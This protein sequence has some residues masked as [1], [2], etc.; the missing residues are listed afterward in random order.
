MSEL[1]GPPDLQRL[2]DLPGVTE[3]L[4]PPGV[5]LPPS[6]PQAPW[7]TRV[8]ATVWWHRAVRGAAGVLPEVLDGPP[9]LP[10]TVAALVRYLDS[11]VGAY[12]EV[13]ASPVLLLSRLPRL[14][15]PFIAVDSLASVRGGRERWGLPKGLAVFDEGTASGAGWQVRARAVLRGPELPVYLPLPSIH[16][17]PDAQVARTVSRVRGRV[18][19]ARVEVGVDGPTLP[20]WLREGTHWGVCGEA[21][22][23]VGRPH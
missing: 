10:L 21:S 13:F 1:P 17:M 20:R 14:H 2:L 15:L 5:Q 7:R 19:L 22:M 12:S 3:S 18:R 16:V 23:V 11:P 4:L 6:S 9:T 8:H